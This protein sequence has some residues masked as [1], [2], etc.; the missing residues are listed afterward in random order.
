MRRAALVLTFVLN[1]TFGN[2]AAEAFDCDGVTLPSSI[3][4]CSDPELMRL[5]DERQE[6]IN[7]ARERIG[8]E[9]WPL[10]WENQQAW[11]RSYAP[12]CGIPQDQPPPIPVSASIRSCFKRAAEA[13]IAFIRAYGAPASVSPRIGPGFDCAEARQPLSLIICAD[14]GLSRADLL[15]N[16]AYWA[17]FQQ[18]GSTGQGKLKKEDLAFLDWVQQ[19]C[20]IPH[21][22]PLP[23]DGLSSRDCVKN[24]FEAQRSTWLA[25]LS[26]PALEEAQRPIERHLALA[27]RLQRLGYVSPTVVIHGVYSPTL[28]TAIA[29]W[30]RDN[31][32]EPTGLLGESDARALGQEVTRGA[33]PV[34]VPSSKVGGPRDEIPL[35]PEGKLF[36]VPAR[37]NDAISLPFILDSGASDVQIPVDVVMTLAR[38]GT[39]SDNDLRETQTCT[40]ADGSRVRCYELMLREL[41]LGNHIV[42]NV[43]ASIGPPKRACFCSGRAFSPVSGY[44]RSTT[45]AMSSSWGAPTRTSE[46]SAAR[47]A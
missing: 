47:N 3:V 42:R 35:T 7:E 26:G 2:G 20:G 18:V 38:A 8:E 29:A 17:L 44:G 22:G 40:L 23:V 28:R 33:E 6:A 30:Q 45:R 39:I 12:A 15:F 10:L 21:F 9:A 37:I 14:P 46:T 31:D 41:R 36:V 16:Q 34:P 1:S 43:V 11:V 13:R 24:A 25:H 32:R 4:I 27:Q 19:R 5:T